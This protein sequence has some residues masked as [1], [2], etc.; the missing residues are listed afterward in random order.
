MQRC[1]IIGGAAVSNYEELKKRL[2]ADDFIICCDSGLNHVEKLGC[3]P[4]LII[5]DFDYHE[6]PDTSVETVVLPCEKDDTD[7]V[8]AVKEAVR[9]GFQEFL[10]LGVIG[11]RFDHSFGNISILLFLMKKGL[12]GVIVDDYSEME[13]A[14]KQEVFIND[15]YSFFSL[16]NISGEA[17]GVTVRNAKYPLEHAEITSDYQYGISNEVLPG[18]V[19]SV[20]VERG[21]LLLVKDF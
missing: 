12:H 20:S 14:G 19:A 1:V 16:L 17:E 11:N 3:R 13:L 2:K 9:R 6:K 15:R 7:T 8:A 18:K 10:F 5:G 4:D 21:C